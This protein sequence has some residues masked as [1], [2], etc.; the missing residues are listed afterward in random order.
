MENSLSIE[1]VEKLKITDYLTKTNYYY[2]FKTFVCCSMVFDHKITHNL[3]DWGKNA[4]QNKRKTVQTHIFRTLRHAK[5]QIFLSFGK[6]V[7]LL[8]LANW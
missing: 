4:V 6:N 3:L 1:E 7:V 5:E 2:I 8:Q